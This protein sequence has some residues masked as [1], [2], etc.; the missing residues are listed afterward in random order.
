MLENN[1]ILHLPVSN[2]NTF[3]LN[4]RIGNVSRSKYG[5][6]SKFSLIYEIPVFYQNLTRQLCEKIP[7]SS[8]AS[9]SE[10]SFQEF[11]DSYIVNISLC[12]RVLNA[13][14]QPQFLFS[15]FMSQ[16]IFYPILTT[17]RRRKQKVHNAKNNLN[18]M[19]C[20]SIE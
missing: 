16:N 5:T 2:R 18:F 15:E 11:R 7:E 6:N 12:K 9:N 14:F 13:S 17:K 3:I 10:K 4:R 1:K 20:K 8:I 19:L